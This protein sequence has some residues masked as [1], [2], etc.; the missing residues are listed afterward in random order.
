ME[1]CTPQKNVQYRYNDLQIIAL[2]YFLYEVNIYKISRGIVNNLSC[3]F[4][5]SNKFL[6]VKETEV[7][8]RFKNFCLVRYITLMGAPI[9]FI[10]ENNLPIYELK[11]P[12]K[13]KK[14]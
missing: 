11:K 4:Y 10:K 6:S 1:N 9:S 2:P 7:V 3:R 14:S 13:K 5:K 8:K 12:I